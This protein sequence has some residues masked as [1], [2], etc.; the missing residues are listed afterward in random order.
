[1]AWRGSDSSRD[2][3]A[4]N[5]G[6]VRA[7]VS[8]AVHDIMDLRESLVL[9]S[10]MLMRSIFQAKSGFGFGCMAI[11]DGR[12]QVE[13]ALC[14]FWSLETT[15]Q[16]LVRRVRDV[17]RGKRCMRARASVSSAEQSGDRILI[18]ID[19]MSKNQLK[20]S[21]NMTASFPPMIRLSFSTPYPA[22]ARVTLSLSHKQSRHTR[23]HTHPPE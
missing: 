1:M 11:M 6:S 7:G 21:S 4:Q 13:L 12:V 10:A 9:E 16:R 17:S 22:L 19:Q 15:D 2:M 18:R 23:T 20:P 14:P 5:I 3:R 8:R